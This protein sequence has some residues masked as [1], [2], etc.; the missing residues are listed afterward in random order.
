VIPILKPG[1]DPNEPKSY[2]SISLTSCM[3]KVMEKIVNRRLQYINVS[4][5]LIPET[6]FGFRR[7]KSTTNVLITLENIIMDAIRKKEYTALLALDIS[8]AYDT[9]WSFGALRK[10]KQWKID[11]RILKLV[12]NFM[13]NRKLKESVGNQYSKPNS[14]ENGI[15]QGVVL[16]VT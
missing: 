12:S 7:N 11:G 10:P 6:Q 15:V 14:I 9:R 13:S 5:R 3:C 1:K 4:R 2:R 16:S 8:K